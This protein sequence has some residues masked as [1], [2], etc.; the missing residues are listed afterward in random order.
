MLSGNY[1]ISLDEKGRMRIPAKF[2]DQMGSD[3]VICAG[4]DGCLFVLSGDN[5][6]QLFTDKVNAIP[7]YD[8]DRQNDLRRIA[9]SIQMVEEDNQGRFVL[10]QNLKNHAHIG[11][12]TVFLGMINRVE[13]WSE[14]EYNARFGDGS[15]DMNA[16]VKNLQI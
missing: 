5:F 4:T 12:K 10:Q 9:G 8:I 6:K 14:E 7:L 1:R 13:I 15:V 11:K 2:H 16:V 3:I